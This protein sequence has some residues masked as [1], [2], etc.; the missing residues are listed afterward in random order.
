MV[1][2]LSL[3]QAIDDVRPFGTG[4]YW[5]GGIFPSVHEHPDAGVKLWQSYLE[6]YNAE[7]QFKGSSFVILEFHHTDKLMERRPDGMAFIKRDKEV[8][9]LVG[10]GWGGVL[11]HGPFE[12]ARSY[13]KKIA[14]SGAPQLKDGETKTEIGYSNW[15]SE[16]PTGYERSI[17]LFGDNYPRLQGVKAKYDPS[18]MFNKWYPVEPKSSDI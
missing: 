16:R 1:P 11:G 7:D 3:N 10:L 14:A 15:E 9:M 17:K 13:A 2:Y 8:I 6:M 18:N 5:Q 4:L 12:K